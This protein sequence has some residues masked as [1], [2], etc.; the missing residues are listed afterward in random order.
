MDY[1][2]INKTRKLLH[3]LYPNKSLKWI[4]DK[5]FKP[6]CITGGNDKFIFTNPDTGSQLLRMG[7]FKPKPRGFP[8]R[9]GVTPYNRDDWDYIEKI[10]FKPVIECLFG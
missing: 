9:F 2:L 5:H 3:R 10:K 7:W 6:D 8:L 1:F 4:K